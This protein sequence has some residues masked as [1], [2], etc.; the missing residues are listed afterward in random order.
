MK[1]IKV[2]K[3]KFILEFI[4]LFFQEDEKVLLFEKLLLRFAASQHK[5]YENIKTKNIEI[6][7]GCRENAELVKKNRAEV[8]D[9]KERL[10]STARWI[11]E[12]EN[13]E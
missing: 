11:E 13:G 9:Q 12:M 8:Q 3:V 1:F 5:E 6:R 7:K 2:K 4:D 10:K